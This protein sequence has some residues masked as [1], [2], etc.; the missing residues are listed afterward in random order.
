MTEL[1][2]LPSSVKQLSVG[3]SQGEQAGELGVLTHG[4][5]Y[6]FQYTQQ[7]LPVS[8]TMKVRS[9]AYNHGGAHPIFSQNLPEGFV[10]RYISEKLAR[11]GKVMICIFWHYRGLMA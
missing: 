8:L 7:K 1:S 2:L 10:R 5:H 3:Y 11:Y 6:S 9:D 4:S